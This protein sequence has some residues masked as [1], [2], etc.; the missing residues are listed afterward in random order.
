MNSKIVF[1]LIASALGLPEISSAQKL[2]RQ[3]IAIVK[4]VEKNHEDAVKFLEKTVNINSGTNN[5]EGVKT[6]GAIYRKMLDDMGFTTTW[7]EMPASM[8]RG[9]HLVAEIKGTKGKKLLL[10]SHMDTV[11]DL[12]S[13]FQKW[14][15]KDSI[16]SGPGAND[17]KGGIMIML[18]ALKAMHETG[19]LKD[20]QIVIVIHGDEESA[21]SPIE[22]SRKDLVDAARRSDYALCFESGKEFNS[23]S[24]ARRGGS[25]WT[26]KVTAKQSHSGQIFSEKAGPGA[27]YETAR[28]LSRFKEELQEKFLTFSPGIMVAGAEANIDSTGL[29]GTAFGKSNIVATTSIVKGDLRYISIEQ[30]EKAR[31]KMLAIV[32]EGFPH[33]E[34]QIT[35][36]GG[37]GAMPPTPGNEK[38]L[39]ILSQASQDLGQGKVTAFDPALR[40]GG[41]MTQI[42]QYIDVVDGLGTV[43]G[44][45]HAPDEY[46]NLNYIE[47]IIKRMAVF[48]HRLS[49]N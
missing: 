35:F 31:T 4:N 25:G 6:V 12:N 28:I 3:E 21:G 2:T 38:L 30:M 45:A 11:F 44:N 48:M 1:L 8:K 42:A 47:G 39:G 32:K 24:I 26:L 16:A 7:V 29:R 22:I 13:P 46:V 18:Y 27:I 5:T 20:R 43:G 17:T 36:S 14:S 10:N 33:T 23:A 37:S 34:A 9:G 40:G 15:V 41:D 19:Q 49:T